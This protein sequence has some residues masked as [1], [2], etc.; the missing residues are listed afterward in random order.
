MHVYKSIIFCCCF[1]GSFHS[2][3]RLP[4]LFVPAASSNSSDA[5]KITSLTGKITTEVKWRWKGEET[6][7]EQTLT[8][9]RATLS[10]HFIW[11]FMI[12]YHICFFFSF[13][14]KLCNSSFFQ[15]FFYVCNQQHESTNQ[16]LT[17]YNG[18]INQL[19]LNVKITHP[20]L[21]I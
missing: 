3:S 6:E 10:L 2:P 4:D 15:S 12:W 8:L 19:H 16:L 18:Q 9:R 13:F 20:P 5:S 17:G 14:F 1:S 7:V 21:R 11:S